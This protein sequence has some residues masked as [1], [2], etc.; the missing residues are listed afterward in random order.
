MPS[1]ILWTL[2]N[3]GP[4]MLPALKGNCDIDGGQM[5]TKQEAGGNFLAVCLRPSPASVAVSSSVPS[6]SGT[7]STIASA[8]IF[9]N[10]LLASAT[11]QSSAAAGAAGAQLATAS[12]SP[13]DLNKR[14]TD[15]AHLHPVVRAKV[16]AV[17]KQLDSEGIP[18]KVFEAFRTPQRQ[19]YLFAKGRTASG[20]KVTNANAWESYHQYGMAADF[21][22]FENGGWNWHDK[23]VKEN[24][25]WD[26]FHEIAK[27][28]GL[29]PLS[30]ERP[31]VQIVGVTLTELRNGAYPAGGD[32]S[33]ASNL[34]KAITGWAGAGA[35]PLPEDSLRPAMQSPSVITS[36]GV[37]STEANWHSMFG[38]D[39]WAYDNKGVY[40]RDHQGNLKTWR[41]VGAP[42]TVQE[43]LAKHGA[44]IAAASAKH[45]V[46]PALI[47][48][49][50]A[51]EAGQ[52]RIDD[53]TGPKTF[54]W[55]Q[56]YAVGA[57]GDNTLDGKEKGDYS[58][59]PMQVLSDTARWMNNL[60]SLGY[61]NAEDLK[62]FKDRP[63]NVPTDL[64]LYKSKICIDIGTAYIKHNFEKTGD[65]PLLV[66]AAYNAG[67]LYASKDNHW[68]IASYGNHIDR[69]AEWYGD[70]CFVL[71]GQ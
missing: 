70:A 23:T 3:I 37:S 53:F 43:I 40:T 2:H 36:L 71:N 45:G 22:R 7:V 34:S 62:F 69:A 33:W 5:L 28:N 38:G 15:L 32:E 44:A 11:P 10:I 54:R 42:I 39:G 64:G 1:Q 58:A 67:G 20:D 63:K 17:Q 56:G 18:M 29:E 48:M 52:Y 50:I 60:M 51:T 13:V 19:A 59:G 35:P 27:K 57:T 41:T 61:D 65:D 21:V 26:R 30:W 8:D 14:F 31:H 46:S 16:A 49:T 6:V 25:E 4:E 12:A 55:E 24:Q 68:R 66:A 9:P 47:V